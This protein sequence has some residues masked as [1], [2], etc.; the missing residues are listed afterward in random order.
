[1]VLPLRA[2][3][4]V[5]ELV[6]AGLDTIAIRIPSHP[7]ANAVLREFGGPLAA[8][9]ANA[10]GTVSPTT[11]WHVIDSLAGRIAAV[12]DGGPCR[13]GLE[14]TIIQM[15]PPKI[16]RPGG[17]DI[18]AI[19]NVLGLPLPFGGNSEQPNAPGQLVS[20]YAPSAAVRLGVTM[21]DADEVWI[22][23]GPDCSNA[24]LNLSPSGDTT[25]AAARLFG[26]LRAAD[27]IARERGA[28]T[29]AIAP[30]PDTGL[31]LA[32]NDRLRRAAA[33]RPANP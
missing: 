8:P 6:T 5:S 1:M 4:G 16:L 24:A 10:S 7:V 29:M 30:V 20:H 21:P 2:D 17:L 13:V 14:S 26:A 33:P 12:I 22:G 3:A 32:I 18:S 25:E 15:D 31:G 28:T 23:F 9:S 27:R 11:A 19:E